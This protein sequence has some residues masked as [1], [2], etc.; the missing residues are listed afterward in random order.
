M[1]AVSPAE[2]T[3]RIFA[4][5]APAQYQLKTPLTFATVPELRGRGCRLIAAAKAKAE[6]TL[7][8]G[9]VGAVDSAGLALL[10]DWV[11]EARRRRVKLHFKQVPEALQALAKLSE[12]DEL[13]QG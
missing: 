1:A 5:V 10:I 7:D 8:L 13:L 6:L 3:V 4:L 11:A 9:E 12:V 2:P